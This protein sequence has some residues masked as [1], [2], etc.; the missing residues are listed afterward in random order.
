MEHPM[1]KGISVRALLVFTTTGS[2]LLLACERQATNAGIVVRDSAGIAIVESRA[3]QWESGKEWSVTPDPVLRVGSVEGQEPYL[4]FRVTDGVVFSD[5]RIA[6][7]N[8]G[9]QEVR[10]YSEAGEHLGTIGG[11]G[12]GPGEFRSPRLMFRLSEDSLAV[13]DFDRISILDPSGDFVR[14][15]TYGVPPALGRFSDGSLLGLG[16][17]AAVDPYELGVV[18]PR[19]ALIRMRGGEFERDT[20]AEVSGS[21]VYR[22]LVA[23]GI[24]SWMRPLGRIRSTVVEQNQIFTGDGSTFEFRVLDEDGS[25]LRIVRRNAD[26]AIRPGDIARFEEAYLADALP[27]QLRQRRQQVLRESPYPDQ[28]PA[29]DRLL[30]DGVRNVWARHYGIADETPRWSVFDPL[31]RWLG[32]VTMPD[33]LEVLEIGDEYVLGRTE[34]SMSVEYVQLHT[35]QK[36]A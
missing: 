2:S 26:M 13:V 17:A 15:Y 24:S 36:P 7:L 21:E 6:V 33:G 27:D 31:G 20:I 30:V 35:L 34:D 22:A 11:Q 16:F 19:M 1:T 3:P 18:C 5:G 10:L 8:T 14:S 23:G 9:T 25:L 12:E 28:L 32:I 4:L 29:Y